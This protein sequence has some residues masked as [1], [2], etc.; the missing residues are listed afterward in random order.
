MSGIENATV[1][2]GELMLAGWSE[3]HTGGAKVT[4]FLPD[5]S[6]LD[7]FRNLTVAKGKMAG[8]RMMAVLVE[9]GDDEMPLEGRKRAGA[10]CKL[11]GMFCQQEQF[12]QWARLNNT[13]EW[14]RATILAK[15]DT[16][17]EVSA[18]WIRLRCGVK[19][20]TELDTNPA[21]EKLF[22][23]RVRNPYAKWLEDPHAVS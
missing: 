22:H 13:N 1:Y 12:W 9:I 6:A 17:Q 14:Q 23:E 7:A 21:A 4:F 20:R 2:K 3:S 16:P 10:L 8:H 15:A 18:E 19:S 5:P 11:A